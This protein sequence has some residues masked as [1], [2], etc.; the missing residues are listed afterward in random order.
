MAKKI[1][2]KKELSNELYTLL[3][4]A[5]GDVW[6]EVQKYTNLNGWCR[7][8]AEKYPNIKKEHNRHKPYWWRPVELKGFIGCASV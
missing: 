4:T 1:D 8:D 2:F 5:Y 3:C 7:L 6:Q